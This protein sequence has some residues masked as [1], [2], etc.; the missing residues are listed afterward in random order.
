M[1]K[2]IVVA[3]NG[4]SRKHFDFTDFTVIGCNA[5]CRD[6]KVDYLVACDKRMVKEALAHKGFQLNSV[7]SS[8][9]SRHLRGTNQKKSEEIIKIQSFRGIGGAG[10]FNF[11]KKQGPGDAEDSEDFSRGSGTPPLLARSAAER[12]FLIPTSA[13]DAMA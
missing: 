10:P 9:P 11:K 2:K 3:G 1:S 5:I 12:N 13:Q 8:R 4:N 6:Y 7:C